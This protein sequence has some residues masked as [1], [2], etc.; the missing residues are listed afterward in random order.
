[1]VIFVVNTIYPGPRDRLGRVCLL[2][3]VRKRKRHRDVARRDQ[4]H[5]Y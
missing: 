4:R 5:S 2:A 1:M 3:G